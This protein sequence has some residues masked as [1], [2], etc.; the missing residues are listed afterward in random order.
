[1]K[2]SDS[3][4]G[5]SRF[6]RKFLSASDKREENPAQ[7]IE[8]ERS[9]PAR[10]TTVNSGGGPRY[11][12]VGRGGHVALDT[13]RAFEAA[14]N[15]AGVERVALPVRLVRPVGKALAK[16]GLLP[17]RR[18]A[19]G[20]PF[21]VTMMGPAEY[22]LFPLSLVAP[23]VVYAFDV[24]PKEYGW[25]AHLFRRHGIKTG[26]FTSRESADWFARKE[27]LESATW[28][29]EGTDV[30]AFDARRRL[31][32]RTIDVLEMGRRHPAIHEAICRPLSEAGLTH[33][34]Q[35]SER[36]LVFASREAFVSGLANTRISVCY[37]AS[38]THPALARGAVEVL[39][40]RYLEALASGCLLVGR[41][42]A[43][44]IA[45]VNYDPV[46][47]LD[48]SAPADH[49]LSLVEH[50]DDFQAHVDHGVQRVRQ[51]GRWDDRVAQ[52]LSVLSRARV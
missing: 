20:R 8:T 36:E 10:P 33:L 40:Q 15:R 32:D 41:A 4:L 37:P 30:D 22:R 52:M 5:D 18:G 48:D 24:W 11:V 17:S 50:I 7:R 13:V 25:W 6:R 39:T 35:P 34:Y 51:V 3:A 28:L 46:V 29:P 23:I 12:D 49:L 2:P 31:R 16:A 21:I 9:N 45:L 14:L 38:D 47:P 43:D 26:F 27:I 1:M 42:P 19:A 44:L